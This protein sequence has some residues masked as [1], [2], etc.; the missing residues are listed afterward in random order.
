MVRPVEVDSDEIRGDVLI[1]GDLV[2][3]EEFIKDLRVNHN[4]LEFIE[5]LDY[6]EMI[7]KH[8][9]NM[10]KHA[11]SGFNDVLY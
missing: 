9:H 3:I 5:P 11:G 2:S 6:A 1:N 8:N 10:H 4:G 7:V